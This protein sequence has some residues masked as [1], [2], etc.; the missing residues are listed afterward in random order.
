[1]TTTAIV[2]MIENLNG[3]RIGLSYLT[4]CVACYH[5]AGRV[6][7][8]VIELNS[9]LGLIETTDHLCYNKTEGEAF[10]RK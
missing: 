4:I 3:N 10:W 8:E 9:C 1:M 5:I 2:D 6:N 7:L